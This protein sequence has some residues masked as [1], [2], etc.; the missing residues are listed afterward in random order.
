MDFFVEKKGVILFHDIP[1][2]NGSDDSMKT[3]PHL[4]YFEL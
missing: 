3:V 1:I 2:I 4:T